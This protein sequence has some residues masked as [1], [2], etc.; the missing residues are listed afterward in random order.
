MPRDNQWLFTHSNDWYRGLTELVQHSVCRRSSHRRKGAA[1]ILLIWF[2]YFARLSQWG[3][4]GLSLVHMKTTCLRGATYRKGGGGGVSTLCLQVINCS[5]K[6]CPQW[7]AKWRLKTFD[8]YPW[9][10]GH[11][12][13]G[14]PETPAS[15]ELLPAPLATQIPTL[16]IHKSGRRGRG[17]ALILDRC[18]AFD[19]F[20]SVIPTYA[21]NTQRQSLPVPI[22][23]RLNSK[24]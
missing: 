3:E 17:G 24:M 1:F 20:A 14:H 2:G 13:Q 19:Q 8:L 16:W 23:Q 12:V 10:E 7:W 15:Y 9:G 4:W 6:K 11:G 5:S 22:C 21:Y 18:R